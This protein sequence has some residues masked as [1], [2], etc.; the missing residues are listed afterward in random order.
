MALGWLKLFLHQSPSSYRP[1]VL[2][3]PLVASRCFIAV[4]QSPQSF[5]WPT[6]FQTTTVPSVS[7][8]MNLAVVVNFLCQLDTI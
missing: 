2:R 7:P 8:Q 5:I 4:V 3:S 6:G 1:F